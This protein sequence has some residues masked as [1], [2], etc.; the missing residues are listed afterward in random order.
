MTQPTEGFRHRYA[1]AIRYGDMDTLGHVNNAKYLTY[2]E[3][4]RIIYVRELGIWSGAQDSAGI[5]MARAVAD[6][7]LP[8]TMDDGEATVWTRTSRIGTKSFD[9]T[10]LIT[11]ERQ[12]ITQVSCQAVITGVAMDYVANQSIR[13]PQDWLDKIHAYEIIPPQ[14]P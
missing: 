4:A 5:I 7:K 2:L 13:I 11:V 8:I 10:S 12:G 9:L 6:Y 3:Q 1:I 14:M